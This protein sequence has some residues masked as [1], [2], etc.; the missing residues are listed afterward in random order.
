MFRNQQKFTTW[1]RLFSPSSHASDSVSL[2]LL[3]Q[4]STVLS[5]YLLPPSCLSF[6]PSW[7]RGHFREL[8]WRM[9]LLLRE[10]LHQWRGRRGEPKER[11]RDRERGSG[12]VLAPRG[13][14][15]VMGEL[16]NAPLSKLPSERH[17]TTRD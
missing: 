6:P 4:Y 9:M 2:L 8:D 14:V 7:T 11:G 13:A 12:G 15:A 3:H 16:S 10:S 1:F 5:L 17:V